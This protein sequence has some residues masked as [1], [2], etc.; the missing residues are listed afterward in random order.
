DGDALRVQELSRACPLAAPGLDERALRGELLDAVVAGVQDVDVALAVDR[1]ALRRVELADP[2]PGRTP[3]RAVLAADRVLD[4]LIAPLVDD[5]DQAVMH[6]YIHWLVDVLGQLAD[7]RA[8]RGEHGD[9][10]AL[11]VGDVD[12]AV[13]AVLDLDRQLEGATPGV[14]QNVDALPPGV[15]RLHAPDARLGEVNE[16]LAI[17]RQPGRQVEQQRLGGSIAPD[18][19]QPVIL[20]VD[21]PPDADA[22]PARLIAAIG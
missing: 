17:Q 8:G 5:V 11:P 19:D 10:A 7:E 22:G 21:R 20:C 16:S 18:G 14:D 13:V 1:H 2:A 12:M 6:R 3:L 4:D 15:E 9:L